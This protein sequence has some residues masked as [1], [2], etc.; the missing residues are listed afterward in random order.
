MNS[1]EALKIAD[2]LLMAEQGKPLSDLQRAILLAAF[3]F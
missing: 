1:E 3:Y 2:D